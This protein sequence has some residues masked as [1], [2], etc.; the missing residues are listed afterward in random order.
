[1]FRTTFIAMVIIAAEVTALAGGGVG[2]EVNLRERAGKRGIGEELAGAPV[3]N[4]SIKAE[5]V[6]QCGDATV[7]WTGTVPPVTLMVGIGGYY[8]G[9]TPL[10]NT[11]GLTSSSATVL[12]NQ[13]QYQDLIFQV[14]DATGQYGYLQNVQVGASPDGDASCLSAGGGGSS[15]ASSSGSGSAT[16]AQSS[17]SVSKSATSTVS[18]S[19]TS[20]S[21]SISS[22]S[23][24]SSTSTTTP[25]STSTSTSIAAA[26]AA[27]SSADST[28]L[29]ATST[30][31]ALASSVSLAA[32]SESSQSSSAEGRVGCVGGYGVLGLTLALVMGVL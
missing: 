27:T 5:N 29:V 31:S 19:S 26:A 15:S 2:S 17:G 8:V 6:V 7:S 9:I 4:I 11:S 32:A 21:K 18:T 3:N 25:T 23:A 28:S 22:K 24:S 1:M 14:T 13:P 10:A 30:S 12:I 20:S 16:S